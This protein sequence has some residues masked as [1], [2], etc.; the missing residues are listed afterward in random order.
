[1]ESHHVRGS[2]LDALTLD[3][4]GPIGL[5]GSE[6]VVGEQ[7][8]RESLA[9][10]PSRYYLT[11]FL[12]PHDAPEDQRVIDGEVDELDVEPGLTPTG[13]DGDEAAERPP[14]VP[15]FLPSSCGLSVLIP[16]DTLELYATLSWGSY[17]QYTDQATRDAFADDVHGTPF[18]VW[19]RTPHEEVL[20]LPI[21]DDDE[22]LTLS[23]PGHPGVDVV[24]TARE[25][26]HDGGLGDG[27]ER[28]LPEGTRSVSVFVVNQKAPKEGAKADESYMFQVSLFLN[29]SQ[30]FVA[31]PNPRGRDASEESDER[32]A[33]L[34]Y[35]HVAE[36]ATG[37]SVS[38]RAHPYV[39]EDEGPQCYQVETIWLP[40]AHVWRTQPRTGGM[41]TSM[42]ALGE[43]GREVTRLRDDLEPLPR[44]YGAWIEEQFVPAPHLSPERADV[45]A[46]LRERAEFARERIQ[47]GIEALLANEDL[48]IAFGIA[49]RAMARAAR[50]RRPDAE[51]TWRT[52]QLAFIL[53]N[54][55]AL[56]DPEHDE[57]EIVDL[58][59]FPT[60]GGK[61]EAYLGLA[62]IQLVLRRLRHEGSRS[63][64][65]VS[66]LMRYTLRLLTLDQLER[67]A[68]MIIALELERR[69]LLTN[70]FERV[71]TFPFEIGLWVGSGA[72]P[73]RLGS[74]KNNKE[75]TAYGK[76]ERYKKDSRRHASPIPLEVCPWC[77]GEFDKRSFK[78]APSAQ[79]PLNLEIHCRNR[80]CEAFSTDFGP[81]PI[82][83]VDEPLYRRLPSMI[84][85]TVDKFANLPWVGETGKLFGRVDSFDGDGYYS[86]ADRPGVART[87]LPD[88]LDP[89]DLILQDELHLISGPVGTMV[90]LYETILE[91]L[92]TKDLG[93][94]RRVRPKI[95]AS[96][97]TI[98][99]ASSQVRALFARPRVEVF[100]PYGPDI[101]DSFFARQL[102]GEEHEHEA[103]L[104]VGV[105]AQGRS[106]KVSLLRTYLALLGAAQKAY[107]TIPH[108]PG[109]LHP[110][111][112]YMTLLGYFNALREL[113]GSRRIIEDEV[114][115]RLRIYGARRRLGEPDETAE[116]ADRQVA[117]EPVELTSRRPTNKIAEAK[118]R[119]ALIHEDKGAVD[120]ALASN[121]ISVGLDI[122][123]LGL[124]VVLGQP[125]S[126]AEYIQATSRVGRDPGRPG[127][128]VTLLNMHRPRDRS[129]YERF[130]TFHASIYR[131]VEAT[132][133]TPFASRAIERG[134]PGVTVGLA[135]HLHGEL[136]PGDH[137]GGV[138]ALR[139]DLDEVAE[140]IGRRAL[141]HRDA[142]GG[143]GELKELGA[144]I[145]G[146]TRH[147]LDAWV[148][149]AEG[150]HEGGL[151]KLNYQRHEGKSTGAHLLY[152]PLEPE[153]KRL[154]PQEALFTANRSLRS[155]EPSV[156]LRIKDFLGGD[157]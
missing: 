126:A 49:N 137:A 72:T 68:A 139:P 148:K 119:L 134:L 91:E 87:P 149:K 17:V 1:M 47:L 28:L 132:S 59:F 51:P 96:T 114:H 136:T 82:I 109:V 125:K 123:R 11:G 129:H 142:L 124:M 95:V 100:P 146:Q 15:K 20:T 42:A 61:T 70:D 143:D 121:M 111:D 79:A 71:G 135:R 52:F 9:E 86:V 105:S 33:D 43:L 80:S 144:H 107:T 102:D 108:Q 112:P 118:K 154:P 50:V 147:L 117:F 157:S 48:R 25:V 60:G 18:R 127:L 145:V 140:I 14:A 8:L 150:V 141:A 75:Y 53:M 66:V 34:Q 29:S 44:A 55:P 99:R 122:T 65:G 46:G 90:G 23:V 10:R 93:P 5:R 152:G 36:W 130:E 37:H 106:T 110:G 35:R 69:A 153:L 67:A 133:V 84:I 113:G 98:R 41:N 76:L 151:A 4:V 131:H 19:T 26:H 77:L 63:G 45:L 64:G 74:K 81:L 89:P 92:S 58:I 78:I 97:A 38:V 62:A 27:S 101:R 7:H 120:I 155:V 83:T 103:R 21:P 16:A 2:L 12:V 13:M 156:H 32:I 30:G 94:G 88:G 57:R 3:L 39:D 31:R 6:Q 116:F 54:L 24:V 138:V 56:I 115:A 22:T 85:S 104:Y 128:V 73:N 40:C